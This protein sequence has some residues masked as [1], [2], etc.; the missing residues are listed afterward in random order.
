MEDRWSPR[1]GAPLI[2]PKVTFR[3]TGTQVQIPAEVR[4]REHET[5]FSEIFP[6]ASE[7]RALIRSSHFPRTSGHE[8]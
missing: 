5:Q 6:E 7:T 3:L 8:R 4:G 1:L 2:D